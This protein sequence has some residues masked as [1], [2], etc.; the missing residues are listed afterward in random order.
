MLAVPTKMSRWSMAADFA[1]PI[2]MISNPYLCTFPTVRP[3]AQLSSFFFAEPMITS[4]RAVLP[5]AYSLYLL[6]FQPL[7]RIDVA[8]HVLDR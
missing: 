5:A 2:P 4:D 6:R 7:V 1:V 3:R 8:S